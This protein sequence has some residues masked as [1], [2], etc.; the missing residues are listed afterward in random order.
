M[1][2]NISHIVKRPSEICT[3]NCNKITHSLLYFKDYTNREIT[4]RMT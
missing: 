3:N 4:E 2:I 1:H